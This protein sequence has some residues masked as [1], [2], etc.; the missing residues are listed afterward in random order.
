M[1]TLEESHS[2]FAI[3]LKLTPNICYSHTNNKL[4]TLPKFEPAEVVK[5]N[6]QADI[7]QIVSQHSAPSQ[8]SR[9]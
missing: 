7:A 5:N 9:Q 3:H 2:S 1:L 6:V 4:I 8:V